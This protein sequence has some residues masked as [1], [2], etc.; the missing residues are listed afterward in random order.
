MKSQFY[1]Y[2]GGYNGEKDYNEVSNEEW[3]E[4]CER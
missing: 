2:F 4:H 3:N 1:V